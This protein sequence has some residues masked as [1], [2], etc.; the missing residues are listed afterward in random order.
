MI[1]V[2]IFTSFVMGIAAVWLLS[3]VFENKHGVVTFLLATAIM[4]G[5]GI[6]VYLSESGFDTSIETVIYSTLISILAVA[7]MAGMGIAR[8]TCRRNQTPRRFGV[9]LPLWIIVLSALGGMLYAVIM[10]IITGEWIPVI[11]MVLSAP[12]VSGVTGAILYLF[13]L[14]FLILTSLSSVYRDR[15]VTVL[16]LKEDDPTKSISISSPLAPLPQTGEG[17]P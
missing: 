8:Y 7:T 13:L 10:S 17:S 14:P 2:T 12:A 1:F 5:V 4:T 11:H 3:F 15:F 9:W 16:R 6:I